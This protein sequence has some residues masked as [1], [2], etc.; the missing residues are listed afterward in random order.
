MFL[1]A[2]LAFAGALAA[3]VII[4]GKGSTAPGEKAGRPEG[5]TA[6]A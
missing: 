4:E 5:E 1:S 2:G 3:A 6:A